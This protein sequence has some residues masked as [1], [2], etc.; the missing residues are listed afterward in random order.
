[1]DVSHLIIGRPWQYDRD[2][3]HIGKK[4]MYSFVFDNLKVIL[5]PR[6][7]LSSLP[8]LQNKVE[9][10]IPPP[11]TK[12][13]SP[14]LLCSRAQFEIEFKDSGFLLAIL[15]TTAK[16]SPP[17]PITP[18]AFVS[19]LQEFLD[20]FPD[21]LPVHLPPLRDIQH[22]IDLVPGEALPN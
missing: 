5:L 13:S 8:I 18:P 15:P 2:T 20:V 21:D 11:S 1:M 9:V 7:E 6:P 19:L 3:S 4:N 17:D 10:Q 16:P 14:T 12:I 22:Q